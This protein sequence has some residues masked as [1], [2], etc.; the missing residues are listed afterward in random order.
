M[1]QI[2]TLLRWRCTAA[3]VLEMMQSCTTIMGW[4]GLRCG[5]W[6]TYATAP[7][8]Q[9]SS[10]LPATEGLRPQLQ[11]QHKGQHPTITLMPAKHC[12]PLRRS[13]TAVVLRRDLH[14]PVALFLLLL[15]VSAV[16]TGQEA[17]LGVIWPTWDCNQPARRPAWLQ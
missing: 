9:P 1:L 11:Q 4:G 3:L 10:A 2:A 17:T 14:P 5:C 7:A 12:A 8:L 6:R 16:F 15:L 13:V